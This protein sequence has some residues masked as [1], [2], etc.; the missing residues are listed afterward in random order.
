MKKV[1]FL[2]LIPIIAINLAGCWFIVGGAAGAAGAYVMGKD[3][4]EGNTD[5]TYDSLW[6]AAMSVARIRGSIQKEDP[7]AGR[8]EVAVESTLVKITLVRVSQATT[9]VRVAARKHHLPNLT[10]AQDIFI[11]IMEEAK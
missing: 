3:Y 6:N 7:M 5:R 10:L 8:I 4:M 1:V 9:K 11:K 2:L